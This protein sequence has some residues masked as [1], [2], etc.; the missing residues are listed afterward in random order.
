MHIF[1]LHIFLD[2]VTTM[3]DMN[4]RTAQIRHTHLDA[5]LETNLHM[6]T[7]RTW[8]EA[9]NS[10]KKKEDEKK[11]A[12]TFLCFSQLMF[13]PIK[14][15]KTVNISLLNVE[16]FWYLP[17]LLLDVHFALLMWYLNQNQQ[18]INGDHFNCKFFSIGKRTKQKKKNKN[19]VDVNK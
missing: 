10:D 13:F 5:H 14:T 4:N 3:K 12:N 19:L 16:N 11:E 7:Y 6:Y 1:K 9:D 8:N 2:D 18:V 17:S 15:E